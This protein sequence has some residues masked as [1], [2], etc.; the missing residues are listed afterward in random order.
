MTVLPARLVAGGLPQA[1]DPGRL[2][3]SV[4]RRRLATVAAIE[5]QPTLQ[6]RNPL[7]L[8]C[9]PLPQP[10]I[11]RQQLLDLVNQLLNIGGRFHPAL[12]FR[13]AR[14]APVTSC[15]PSQFAAVSFKMSDLAENAHGHLGSYC[16]IS[17]AS[18]GS[19]GGLS[20]T[21]GYRLSRLAYSVCPPAAACYAFGAIGKDLP[22]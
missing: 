5:A 17:P 12:R 7:L 3:Q 22:V 8:L 20:A 6:L 16:K 4:T 21:A 13:F 18:L 10:T 11:F 1:P 19:R 15:R 9:N 2:L 14:P